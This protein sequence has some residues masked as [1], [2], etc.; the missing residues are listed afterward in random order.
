MNLNSVEYYYIR[1][2]QGDIIGLFNKTGTQVVSYTYDSWGKPY[3]TDAE[4]NDA[5]D[6]VKD[7][8]TGILASAVDVKNPYI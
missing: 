8:I 1:N 3:V 4:R 5:S 2:A 6:T 7:G